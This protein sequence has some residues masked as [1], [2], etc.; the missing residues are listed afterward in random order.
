MAVTAYSS[1]GPQGYLELEMHLGVTSLLTH[2]VITRAASNVNKSTF[3]VFV[4]ELS[5]TTMAH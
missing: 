4:F 1:F 2:D 5:L 3:V